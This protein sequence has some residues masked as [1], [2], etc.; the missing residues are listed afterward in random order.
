MGK[1]A[2]G[3]QTSMRE[4]IAPLRV[5]DAV[6]GVASRLLVRMEQIVPAMAAI[7]LACSLA[8]FGAAWHWT[9]QTNKI[10]RLTQATAQ[11]TAGVD[12]RQMAAIASQAGGVLSQSGA[13]H[14]Q[15]EFLSE[16]QE[17][18]AAPDMRHIIK[19]VQAATPISMQIIGIN[20]SKANQGVHITI[21]GSTQAPLR[22]AVGDMQRLTAELRH[23]GYRVS[24]DESGAIDENNNFRLMMVWRSDH[25]KI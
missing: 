21:D 6:N 2:D 11:Q 22:Q 18:L 15:F 1:S 14:K 3:R 19:D 12:L 8:L 25:G 5:G 13:V 20:F 17:A 16:I 4:F 9:N 10:H 24:G 23:R 7:V